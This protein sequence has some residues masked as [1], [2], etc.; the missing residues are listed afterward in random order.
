VI[1]T[2]LADAI[3]VARRGCNKDREANV[4]MGKY[5]GDGIK[6][7]LAAKPG[8]RLDAEA[9][10]VASVASSPRAL[11]S[12]PLRRGTGGYEVGGGAAG[13]PS[14]HLHSIKVF[15][16][17]SRCAACL[18]PSAAA[19]Y[20]SCNIAPFPF[21]LTLHTR[22]AVGLQDTTPIVLQPHPPS[23]NPSCRVVLEL[24][25][26]PSPLRL[27]GSLLCRGRLA[28]SRPHTASSRKAEEGLQSVVCSSSCA[29]HRWVHTPQ[30]AR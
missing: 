29:A 28:L 1:Q 18:S 26:L 22:F 23:T 3:N 11:P 7:G 12:A 17:Q 20:H 21:S 6:E 14:E 4:F 15:A 5:V 27:V 8:N 13:C 2:L 10:W 9:A 24:A 30:L 25:V 19:H 16:R